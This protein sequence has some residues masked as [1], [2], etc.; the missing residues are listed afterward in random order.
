MSQGLDPVRR[1]QVGPHADATQGMGA[2]AIGL[3]GEGVVLDGE[4]EPGS[5]VDQLGEGT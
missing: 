1:R 2:V 3:V 4:T 5:D